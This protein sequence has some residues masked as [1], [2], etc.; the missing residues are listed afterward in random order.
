MGS[1]GPR[2]LQNRSVGMEVSMGRF[3]SDTPPPFEGREAVEP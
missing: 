1:G 3:D 2:G